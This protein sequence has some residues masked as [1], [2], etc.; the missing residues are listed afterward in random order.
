MREN[1]DNKGL[2]HYD[3]TMSLKCSPTSARNTY[4][5]RGNGERKHLRGKRTCN[6]NYNSSQSNQRQ[7]IV[8]FTVS[9]VLDPIVVL[10]I[11]L[12]FMSK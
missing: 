5:E 7:R 2:H 11:N 9:E 1:K 6:L 3:I 4:R 8:V 10:Y 12:L